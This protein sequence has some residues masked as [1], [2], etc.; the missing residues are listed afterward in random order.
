LRDIYR[1]C[2]EQYLQRSLD[3]SSVRYLNRTSLSIGDGQRVAL[4]GK[5]ITGKRLIYRAL[6]IT[7]SKR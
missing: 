1:F 3:E 7:I 2:G 5:D 6:I 4:I